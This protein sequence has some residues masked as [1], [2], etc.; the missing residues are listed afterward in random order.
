MSENQPSPTVTIIEARAVPLGGLRAMNV[1]RTLPHR[2][3]STVGAWCFVDHY[4]PDDASDGGMIVPPHPHTGLQTVSW[5]F[6]GEIEH[7]DS[8]GSRQLVRP[9]ELNLMTAGHGISHSEVSTAN[10]QWLH[11]VQLWT[12]LPDAARHIAPHFEHHVAQRTTIGEAEALVFIGELAGA[13][14]D[15]TTYSP[16]L[17]AEIRI[18]ANTVI[19]IPTRV[20]F[21]HGILV[22]SGDVRLGETRVPR[23]AL[24]IVDAGATSIRLS[25]GDAPA[26]IIL[27]GGEPLNESFVM[28]WN[29]IGRSHEEIVEMRAQWQIDVADAGLAADPGNRFGVVAGYPGAALPAP[30]TP[31]A[32]LKPRQR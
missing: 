25:I 26:R 13:G 19:D 28:W 24:G 5:L 20:T 6:D 22:D 17:G 8:V 27:I 31:L 18:P 32:R 21:E 2:T 12:L 16:L 7:R 23:N 29:F 15:A 3:R 1:R 11:G 14:T 4:G 9:G 30:A 10:T